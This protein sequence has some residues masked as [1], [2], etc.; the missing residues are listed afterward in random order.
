MEVFAANEEMFNK[1]LD[2]CLNSHESCSDQSCSA[3]EDSLPKK[4]SQGLNVQA[5]EQQDAQH[6]TCPVCESQVNCN[7]MNVH[8]DECLNKPVISE[9][10]SEQTLD[11]K[12]QSDNSQNKLS[13]KRAKTKDTNSK[14]ILTY[15]SSM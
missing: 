7:Q 10:R 13:S 8:L 11:R 2:S 15:F 9:I 12:R 4:K 3:D 6:W 5:Q 1:H 14:S